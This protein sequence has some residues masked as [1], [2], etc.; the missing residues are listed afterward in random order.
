MT[1]GD[2]TPKSLSAES[3]S[4]LL[5]GTVD[6]LKVTV[7]TE[8]D[9]TNSEAKRLAA[10]GC[11]NPLLIISESQT[12]GRGRMGRSFFSPNGTGLYMSFMY[13]PETEF[14]DTVT[15]TSA[16]AVAVVRALEE[17][18]D[19]T[20][21][22]KWVNDVYVSGKKVCGILTEAVTGEQTHVIVGIGINI[23]TDEFP[24]E[25]EQKAASIGKPLDRNLLAASITKH[26]CELIE[27]LPQRTFLTEYR[28]KSMVL[29]RTVEFTKQ[30]ESKVGTAVDIDR[31]GGLIVDTDSGKITLN[32][33]E[34][35]LKIV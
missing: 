30:G 25:I 20:A 34:I 14:S 22:I 32:T 11:D 17:M 18:T 3:I 4:R 23:T 8:V 2:N 1:D 31:N 27:G 26:L 24:D 9:S 29:G 12:A 6:R 7:L 16:S 5:K 15:V 28:E 10:K 21:R 13:R 35:S 19:L 33:G